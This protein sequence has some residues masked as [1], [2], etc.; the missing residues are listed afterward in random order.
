[1]AQIIVKEK[2]TKFLSESCP[3]SIRVVACKKIMIFELISTAHAAGVVGAG[4]ASADTPKPSA[5]QS[6]GLLDILLS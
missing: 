5:E 6:T 1:M 2:C 4:R 3:A